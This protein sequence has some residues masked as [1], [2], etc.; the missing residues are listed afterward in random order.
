ME[1]FI[2]EYIF[3]FGLGVVIGASLE[4]FKKFFRRGCS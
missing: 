4:I 2:R 1:N 3:A